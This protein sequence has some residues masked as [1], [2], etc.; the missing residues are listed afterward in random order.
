M[1]VKELWFL[2]PSVCVFIYDATRTSVFT[3]S[4]GKS[5]DSYLIHRFSIELRLEQFKQI[6]AAEPELSSCL[7]QF[8]LIA[9]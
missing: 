4:G 1:H 7:L 8:L 3:N 6:N 5:I 2:S 9:L